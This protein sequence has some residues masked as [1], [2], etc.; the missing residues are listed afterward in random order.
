MYNYVHLGGMQDWN[1]L[2]TNCFEI[3]LELGCHKFPFAKDLPDYWAAN[4]Y[5]L[6]VFMGQAHKGVRGF[7][8]D[9]D[10]NMPIAN[11]TLS[12]KGINHT[13][14]TAAD[15]DYWRLLAPGDYV[16]SVSHPW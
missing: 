16:I 7:V 5:A 14:T 4:K 3:T 6:L 15:G 1:Y 13:I 11:V 2:H 9:K 12:V 10:T 8:T